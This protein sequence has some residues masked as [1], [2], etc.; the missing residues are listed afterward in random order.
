MV[1]VI[2]PLYSPSKVPK[3]M[4]K[5]NSFC[6]DRFEATLV[7]KDNSNEP[8][9]P[10]C[11]PG[12]RIN[13]LKAVS[14]GGAV[15]QGY[16]NQIQAAQAC[17][18]AGKFLC[19]D[20]QWLTACQGSQRASCNNRKEGKVHPVNDVFPEV[21]VNKGIE[22]KYLNDPRINKINV[23]NSFLVQTGTLSSCVSSVGAYDMVGNVEEWTSDSEGTFRGGYYALTKWPGMGEGCSYVTKIHGNTYWD[24]STGFRCCAK[25][26]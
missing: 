25:P 3:G 13:N 17:E 16:L 22:Q 5:V 20:D 2:A 7:K 21:D 6:I 18:T 10:Y 23:Q 9:S 14:L 11:N 8:W 24:Y 26:S 19:S 4:V 1:A 12:T 15:P